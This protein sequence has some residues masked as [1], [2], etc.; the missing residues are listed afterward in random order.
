VTAVQLLGLAQPTAK[1]AGDFIGDHVAGQPPLANRPLSL[2]PQDLVKSGTNPA[3]RANQAHLAQP[4]I[5]RARTQ[6]WWAPYAR[7]SEFRGAVLM[8]PRAGRAEPADRL[9]PGA[10]KYRAHL[11]DLR[12]GCLYLGAGTSPAGLLPLPFS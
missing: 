6:N 11:L 9:G 1:Y 7:R 10:A 5:S 3:R 12:L 8:S 4:N 2:P